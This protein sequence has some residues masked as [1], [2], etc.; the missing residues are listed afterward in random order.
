MDMKRLPKWVEHMLHPCCRCIQ[1][2]GTPKLETVGHRLIQHMHTSHIIEN[3]LSQ[4]V[5]SRGRPY[6]AQH[7]ICAH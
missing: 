6:D 1:Y 2:V 4:H 7:T 3:L 5:V